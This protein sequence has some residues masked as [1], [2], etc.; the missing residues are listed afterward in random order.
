MPS[1]INNANTSPWPSIPDISAGHL[2]LCKNGQILGLPFEQ[3][4]RTSAFMAI[5]DASAGTWLA[6]VGW[7]AGPQSE[8]NCRA[9]FGRRFTSARAVQLASREGTRRAF[10]YCGLFAR[11]ETL[12]LPTWGPY[13]GFSLLHRQGRPRNADRRVFDF[14]EG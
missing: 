13:R 14:A 11:P 4:A 6:R 9:G 7:C 5:A 12:R 1:E 8:R 2:R 10:R 3:P